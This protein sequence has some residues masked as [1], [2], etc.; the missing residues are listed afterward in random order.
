MHAGTG[1]GLGAGGPDRDQRTEQRDE[2]GSCWLSLGHWLPQ[3]QRGSQ[4]GRVWH[5]WDR[6]SATDA[7]QV[8]SGRE[9]AASDSE[10]ASR[11]VDD[12]V[13]AGVATE[14]P[15]AARRSSMRSHGVRLERDVLTR[16]LGAERHSFGRW[17]R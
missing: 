14:Q 2:R 17:Y 13:L 4:R 1:P 6:D 7:A 12:T 5:A 11:S 10:P 3:A 8:I 9:R 16:P 15:G